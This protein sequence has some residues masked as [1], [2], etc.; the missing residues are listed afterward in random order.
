MSEKKRKNK[1]N[2][3]CAI[4]N[5]FVYKKKNLLFLGVEKK[6]FFSSCVQST[7]FR[8][9]TYNIIISRVEKVVL[10]NSGEKFV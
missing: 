1:I 9:E 4:K 7:F 5:F 10:N 2:S 6:N 8:V 3:P